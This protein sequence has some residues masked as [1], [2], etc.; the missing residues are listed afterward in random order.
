MP[1]KSEAIDTLQTSNFVRTTI[2][3]QRDARPIVFGI[4]L[5]VS[6]AMHAGAAA[7]WLYIPSSNLGSVDV[8]TNAVSVN[9]ETTD[10]ID[11]LESAAARQASSS[12]AGMQ[13]Q[14]AETKT[15][16]TATS[17]EEKPPPK[18]EKAEEKT[19]EP[20][21][22]R[23]VEQAAVEQRPEPQQ[24][25]DSVSEEAERKKEKQQQASIPGGAGTSGSEE[26]E[27]SAGRISA[28][29]GSILNYGAKLRA[30]ISSHAPRNI[31]GKT[32]RI[33]F[34]V[35]PAGGLVSVYV[36]ESSHDEAVDRKVIDFVRTLF[37]S[38]PPPPHGAT[39][40]QLAFNIQIRFR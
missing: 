39:P 5:G 9:L 26:A 40:T 13:A 25:K 11:A 2:L 7:Y 6:L 38:L 31:R 16:E 14:A 1:P 15:P 36:V 30:M 17:E 34:N 28:S 18:A 23:P 4:A 21:D 32:L 10:V 35:A 33:A 12:P 20:Q 8:P 22:A 27:A 24:A 19:E 3:K 29:E 37:T